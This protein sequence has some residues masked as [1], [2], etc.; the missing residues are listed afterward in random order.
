L[1]ELTL[2]LVGYGKD[3]RLI[4][5]DVINGRVWH[6]MN[7][8]VKER[9]FTRF[10]FNPS[11]S[12]D[13]FLVPKPPGTFRIFCLGGST[14]VG[15]PYWYNAALSSFLRDRL[16]LMLPGRQVDVINLAMT[17]T[18]SFTV[19]DMAREV[20][21]YEPDLVIVYDGHNEFY[22]ALGV[23]SHESFSAPRW[24]KL[25]S[26]RL[27]RFYTVQLI[28]DGIGLFAGSG[29][30]PAAGRPPGT[31]MEKLARGRAIPYGSS[32]YREGEETFRRNLEDL[33]DLLRRHRVPLI[34]GTQVSNLRDQAPFVSGNIPEGPEESA[35]FHQRF[36][37]GISAFLDGRPAEALVSLRSLV[38]SDSL[39]AETL[40]WIA[41]C[42]D[43]LGR[44]REAEQAY[45]LARDYDQLR[46]RTSSDFNRIILSMADDTTTSVVD[47][48]QAFRAHSPDSLIGSSLIFE[49]LH[50]RSWGE[51]LM[52]QAYAREMRRRGL[53]VP[54]GEW[55][56]VDMRSDSLL[57]ESRPVT[58]LDERTA[59]R[60]TEVLMSGW[61]FTDQFPIVDAVPPGDTLGQLAESLVRA[62][63]GWPEA[64]D[65]A[66]SWYLSR[67]DLAAAAKE[68]RAIVNQLPMISVQPYLKLARVLVA[69]GRFDELDTVFRQSLNVTPTILA[70]R[71]LGDIARQRG[72]FAEAAEW[73]R[74]TFMFPQQPGEQ[75]ENGTLLALSLEA[76][77]DTTGARQ[78]A[79]RVLAIRPDHRPAINLLA[80]LAVRGPG[81][82]SR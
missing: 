45:V 26:L 9:Y 25:L 46:F 40:Y 18:N 44:P 51:Y 81:V 13:Y 59:S 35:R 24:L 29:E 80:R 72:R 23:A 30:D 33:R 12:P 28:R 1:L 43:T 15:F 52:A 53:P 70:V 75:A 65:E 8:Y 76:A 42:L 17:A 31:M 20:V 37:E 6:V 4:A 77:G 54:A 11:T 61:P 69:L 50:P 38:P 34:L 27:L 3:M 5:T 2:R 41:R 48:E 39:R 32:L 14:T 19:L 62:R 60:R 67:N 73:Y 64:H 36:N 68:Y 47:V 22:G 74:K 82:T 7:P 63:I 21:E 57:W 58:E 71:A 66:A 78:E 10:E 55:H 16:R 79:G 49:H 56:A